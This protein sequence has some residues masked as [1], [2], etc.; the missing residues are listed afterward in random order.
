MTFNVDINKIKLQQEIANASIVDAKASTIPQQEIPIGK[1]E[2]ANDTPY[3][4]LGITQEEYLKLC[5]ENPEFAKLS[6]DEQLK[7]IQKQNA[8][9]VNT[10]AEKPVQTVTAGAA[11]APQTTTT[12]QP[13]NV[14]VAE[15]A[16]TT[17][18]QTPVQDA[19]NVANTS[20]ASSRPEDLDTLWNSF[21]QNDFSK[22]SVEEQ[23][24][25]YTQELAKNKFVYSGEQIRAV[26][27]WDALSK[28]EQDKYIADAK[29]H[30]LET[31]GIDS[32]KTGKKDDLK[33]LFSNMMTDLQSANF[34]GMSLDEFMS[35]PNAQ[36]LERNNDYLM[37]IDPE[38]WSV[39]NKAFIENEALL[40][41][42]LN[43]AL[44]KVDPSH[45]DFNYCPAELREIIEKQKPPITTIE[46]KYQYLK[47]QFEN[48]PSV[49]SEKEQLEFKALDK[50]ANTVSGK[51]FLERLKHCSENPWDVNM[52]FN[53]EIEKSPFGKLYTNTQS[54]SKERAFVIKRY[55]ESLKDDPEKLRTAYDHYIASLTADEAE[56]ATYVASYVISEFDAKDLEAILG[57][58]DVD[59]Q[60]LIRTKAGEMDADQLQKVAQKDKAL[61][62][63]NPAVAE[64]FQMTVLDVMD[65][66]KEEST[67]YTET[68]S[69][70]K[71]QKVQEKTVD[72]R[73]KVED[74]EIFEKIDNQIKEN[75]SI[76]T[77]VKAI[78]TLKHTKVD[79]NVR[80]DSLDRQLEDGQPEL[81][82][83]GAGIVADTFGEEA[84]QPAAKIVFEA[85]KKLEKK[86]AIEAQTILADQIELCEAS[87]Q[88]AIHKMISQ[89]QYEEVVQHAAENIYK[90]AESAQK[91][92]MKYTFETGNQKAIEAAVSN[93]DRCEGL[94]NETA[95][96]PSNSKSYDSQLSSD[97]KTYTAQVEQKY[98]QQAAVQ[99]AEYMVEQDIRTGLISVDEKQEAIQKYIEKFKDP[100][101]NKFAL[102]G[103]LEPSQRKEAL[104]II[105]KYAPNLINSFIDLGY[106]PQILKIIGETSDLAVKIVELMDFKGQS[107][108][109]A[110]VQKYPDHF[111]ELYIKYFAKDRNDVSANNYFTAPM[112][113][114]NL[115]QQA[116][117]Q[118]KLFL[119]G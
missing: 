45:Q 8:Q 17:V 4:K 89:S 102:L 42:A 75:S 29:T 30:L 2:P 5:N 54:G 41:K 1:S 101:T 78:E 47:E 23:F 119:R 113:S 56:E 36:K 94:A 91:D 60:R 100:S 49:L 95:S 73:N 62:K 99:Y 32:L 70:A 63:S 66:A 46:L 79:D 76:K 7:Y 112:P 96:V 88:A 9:P 108:A 61:E 90:Y 59:G 92:A 48:D 105:V 39:A 25:V 44:K 77:R 26:A 67:I 11:E 58:K 114:Y 65:P 38:Q 69:G 118:G 80:L 28:E 21:N 6:F 93:I 81:V 117:R 22:L 83:A 16:D 33:L 15:T 31:E 3:S 68:T 104:K 97:I 84:E 34:Y 37:A 74:V 50:I 13:V 20:S 24:N 53:A 64:E 87:N 86:D 35:A 71:S 98:I 103:Q 10:P 14:T 18:A 40:N 115:M 55:M 12:A 52:D 85:S 116:N 111:E 57:G 106:G 51:K 72:F 43:Y 27:E 110:I 107:E 82:K 19:G 109:K